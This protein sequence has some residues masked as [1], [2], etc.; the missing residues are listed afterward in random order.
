MHAKAVHSS[1]I[2]SSVVIDLMAM[3]ASSDVAA[4]VRG[5]RGFKIYGI[6]RSYRSLCQNNRSHISQLFSPIVSTIGLSHINPGHYCSFI[7]LSVINY[8]PLVGLC[9][10]AKI[11]PVVF[12]VKVG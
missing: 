6:R 1:H 4:H 9:N 7:R 2:R 8:T 3:Q 10:S 12:E 11:G 5:K